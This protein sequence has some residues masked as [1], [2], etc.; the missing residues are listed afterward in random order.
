LTQVV[1]A[2][3]RQLDK[4]AKYVSHGPGVPTALALHPKYI[5]IGTKKV[6]I[7]ST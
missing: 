1:D 6:L 7:L 3:S 5:A 2:I 4:N